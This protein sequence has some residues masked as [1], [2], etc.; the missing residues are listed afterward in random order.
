MQVVTYTHS[1]FHLFVSKR[2]EGDFGK[3]RELEVAFEA[4]LTH[5][6]R[7]LAGGMKTM[8]WAD[9]EGGATGSILVA[10]TLTHTTAFVRVST[11]GDL[12][13][14]FPSIYC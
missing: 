7:S 3:V 2:E 8:E 13:R 14:S 9:R 5:V 6:E 4:A 1:R 11:S 10:V 12:S